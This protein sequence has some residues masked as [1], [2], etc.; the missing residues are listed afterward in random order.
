MMSIPIPELP[1]PLLVCLPLI[2]ASR[3]SSHCPADLPRPSL[4]RPETRFGSPVEKGSGAGNPFDG[5]GA[6]L[7]FREAMFGGAPGEREAALARTF[8]TLGHVAH[9]IQDLAVP[10]HVRNDFQAHLQYLNP[11]AGYGR[12]TENGLERFVRRNPRLVTEAAA[13]AATLAVEFTLKPLT[14]FWDLDLYMGATPSRDTA[15]GLAGDT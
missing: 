1:R 4:I 12:W 14:R 15:Q 9:L 8:E 13:A 7:A 2:P 3:M 6:R 10:A 5:D 11:F